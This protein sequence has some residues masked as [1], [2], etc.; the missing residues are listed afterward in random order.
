MKYLKFIQI[1]SMKIFSIPRILKFS[2]LMI[3]VLIMMII[4]SSRAAFKGIDIEPKMPELISANTLQPERSESI[5]N[6]PVKIPLTN[7][8]KALNL[9]I[10][11]KFSG[12]EADPTDLLS[13]DTLT[14]EINRKD[15]SIGTQ[16]N[17]ITFSVPISGTARIK[18]KVNLGFTKIPVS[19]RTNIAGTIFGDLSLGIDNEWNIQPN[20]NVSTNLTKADVPIKNVGTISIRSILKKQ[21]D[22][23]INKEKPKLIAELVEKLNLKTEVT[24]QWNNLHLSERVNQDPSIWIKTEPQSVSFKE[25]DLSDGENVQS[26]IA[27]KMFVDT[28][29]CKEAPVVNFKPLPNLIIQDQIIDKFLIN[30]PVQ[31]SVDE[32]NNTLQSEVRG[33][34]L[35]VD[36]NLKVIVNEINLSPLGEKILVKVDF[37]TDKG[38]LLQGAKG[39]LYLW[40]KIFY[41]QESNNLKVVELDYDV[42]TKNALLSTA[43]SLL[44]PVLLQQIEE[45]LSFPLDKELN[46]AKD[47]ANKYIQQIKLPP[48]IDANIEVKKI[49]VEKVVVTNNDIFLVLLA[50]GNMAAILNLEDRE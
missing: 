8:Q 18:G 38:S 5:L 14:Y 43:D 47:E 10:S 39:I 36:E 27:I 32:L 35:S 37:K 34:S 2:I 20:L 49:E 15:L 11:K 9:N 3:F 25:F 4:F 23:A 12:T 22:K 45:R 46:R 21:V 31:V 1:K 26:G 28:C 29:I 40:G 24:K 42:D 44:K 13:N 41:D 50:D 33:K 48:E 30:L 17:L 16:N 7:I 6:L 19:A